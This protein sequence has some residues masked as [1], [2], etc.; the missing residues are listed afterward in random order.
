MLSANGVQNLTIEGSAGSTLRMRRADYANASA[1]EGL[2]YAKSEWRHGITL[3]GVDGVTI[4]GLRCV[5][6]LARGE[7][8]IEC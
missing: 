6:A 2:V 5:S 3:T 7:S 1:D 4:R 8:V